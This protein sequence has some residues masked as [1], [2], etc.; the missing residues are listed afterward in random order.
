MKTLLSFLK[1]ASANSIK[2]QDTVYP[3]SIL[4]FWLLFYLKIKY[5]VIGILGFMRGR[6][7]QTRK[8]RN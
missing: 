5:A 3:S 4:L 7:G 6:E 2:L 8:I 1:A